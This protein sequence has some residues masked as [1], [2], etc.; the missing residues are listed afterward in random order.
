VGPLDPATLLVRQVSGDAA[1]SALTLLEAP[2]PGA[3][4]GV[5]YE[6]VDMGS[7][8][9]APIGAALTTTGADGTCHLALFVS[10]SF[11]RQGLGG[12]ILAEVLDGLRREGVTR[13]DV[14]V[15]NDGPATRL[16]LR[17][18]FRPLEGVAGRM[19]LDL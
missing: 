17:A 1:R 7:A 14:K 15:G 11:R 18:G 12:R 8:G 6:L 5:V 19:V 3:Q 4:T 16:C 2:R 13:V 9:A 10:P